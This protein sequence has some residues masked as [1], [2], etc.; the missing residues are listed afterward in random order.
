MQELANRR[1]RE[2]MLAIGIDPEQI[3]AGKAG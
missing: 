1:W 3:K 2:R